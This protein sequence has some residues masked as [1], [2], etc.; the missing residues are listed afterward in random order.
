MEVFGRGIAIGSGLTSREWVAEALHHWPGPPGVLVAT[1]LVVGGWRFRRIKGTSSSSSS[2]DEPCTTKFR[3]L[4][5]C[6]YGL[7]SSRT[8]EPA[9]FLEETYGSLV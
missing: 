9:A 4:G 8:E 2:L 1:I 5:F 6:E 3:T 7:V